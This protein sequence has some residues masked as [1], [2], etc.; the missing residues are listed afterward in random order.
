LEQR[1]EPSI[2]VNVPSAQRNLLDDLQGIDMTSAAFP[3]PPQQ[4]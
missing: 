3:Q 4:A 2:I 1:T